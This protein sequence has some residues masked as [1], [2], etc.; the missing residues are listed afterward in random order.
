MMSDLPFAVGTRVRQQPVHD[1]FLP[2]DPTGT[3]L[4]PGD[5]P[6]LVRVRLD[7]P[8][9]CTFEDDEPHEVLEY[10]ADPATL[11]LLPHD[12]G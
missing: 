4:G 11:D 1:F 8:A 3:V 2:A 6:G 12:G 5:A 10:S 9:R 7:A